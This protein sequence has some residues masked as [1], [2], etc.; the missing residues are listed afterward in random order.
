MANS[1][2]KP[3]MDLIAIDADAPT[4]ERVTDSGR[5]CT[6][7]ALECRGPTCACR[8][9][10]KADGVDY[11]VIQP[12]TSTPSRARAPSGRGF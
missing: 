3:S 4:G 5:D 6:S 7:A 1:T 12:S 2:S 9:G 8:S 10:S 11:A